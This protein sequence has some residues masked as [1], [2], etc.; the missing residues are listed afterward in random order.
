MKTE[1]ITLKKAAEIL[2]GMGYHLICEETGQHGDLADLVS[3]YKSHYEGALPGM[4]DALS[5][6][7][8]Q[9]HP[10][11]RFLFC[12]LDMIFGAEGLEDALNYQH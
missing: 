11:L 12:D 6:E 2:G 1:G 9:K 10:A 7:Y 3:Y 8:Q 5:P 4:F